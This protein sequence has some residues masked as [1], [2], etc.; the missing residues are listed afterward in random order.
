[1]VAYAEFRQPFEKDKED[2][3]LVYYGIRYIIE[4]YV[5]IKWTVEMVEQADKFYA[6]HN[7]GKTKFPFPKDL[8]LKFIKENN[9]YFPCKIESLPEGSVAYPHLPVYQITTS[10]DYAPLCTWLETLLT[11]VWYPSTVATL[12]RRSKD[13]IREAFV[14]SVDDEAFG[15][16][17]R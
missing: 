3:R 11:M 5:A 9:G 2:S 7:A 13:L 6:T 10:D 8:I 15:L 16:L 4:H 1:M 14:K 17:D 12:S